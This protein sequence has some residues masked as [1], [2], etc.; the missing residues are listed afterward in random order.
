MKCDAFES[1]TYSRFAAHARTDSDWE[2]AKLFQDSADDDRTLHFAREA[3]LDGLV[4]ESPENL[5]NALDAEREEF[6]MYSKFALEATADGDLAAAA[7]FEKIC[8]ERTSRC[9]RLEAL[10]ADMG[11]HS[12]IRTVGA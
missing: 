5:R 1:A 12:D 6:K 3:E 11:L 7:A 9:N 4:T 10:L 8:H 2:L